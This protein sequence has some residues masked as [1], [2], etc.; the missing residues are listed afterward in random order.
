MRFL[1]FVSSVLNQSSC[2][3]GVLGNGASANRSWFIRLE[4]D[5]FFLI[6]KVIRTHCKKKKKNQP[7][8]EYVKMKIKTEKLFMIEGH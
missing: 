1:Q 5:T 7:I 3:R 8:Q 2:V 4:C 6:I